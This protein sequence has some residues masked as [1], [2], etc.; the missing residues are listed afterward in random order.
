MRRCEKPPGSPTLWEATAP[1]TSEALG[2]PGRPRSLP[3]SH[4]WEKDRNTQAPAESGHSLPAALGRLIYLVLLEGGCE[5]IEARALASPRGCGRSPPFTCQRV[6]EERRSAGAQMRGRA[7]AE[8]ESGGGGAVSALGASRCAPRAPQSSVGHPTS[9][10]TPP[11]PLQGTAS[12][13]SPHLG[14]PDHPLGPLSLTRVSPSP[15]GDR[16]EGS[17]VCAFDAASSQPESTRALRSRRGEAASRCLLRLGPPGSSGAAGKE[18]WY[19]AQ[20]Q[21]P[22]PRRRGERGPWRSRKLF[23]DCRPEGGHW[24]LKGSDGRQPGEMNRFL[25][26]PSPLMGFLCKEPRSGLCPEEA[27]CDFPG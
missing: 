5:R 19:P 9:S 16:R 15:K 4:D 17:G 6:W 10:R 11:Q 24:G 21:G 23:N 3:F 2:D 12:E 13:W 7:E 18:R 14:F 25:K 22:A 27:S 20:P 1:R 26:K 8:T